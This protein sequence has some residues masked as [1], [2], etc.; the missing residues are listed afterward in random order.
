[1]AA[2][3]T[4]TQRKQHA[5]QQLTDTASTGSVASYKAAAE[6]AEAAAAEPAVLAR[7]AATFTARC[8]QA[9]EAL[10]TAAR[11]G[12]WHEFV[13]ARDQALF[14]DQ[15]VQLAETAMQQRRDVASSAVSTA[16]D[17]CLEAVLQQQA[18]PLAASRARN[19]DQHAPDSSLFMPCLECYGLTGHPAPK[20]QP[21]GGKLQDILVE[22]L[23]QSGNDQTLFDNNQQIIGAIA[24]AIQAVPSAADAS[25]AD[26]THAM[27]DLSKA[28]SSQHPPQNAPAD[29]IP[30]VALTDTLTA[31]RQLGLLQTVTLALHTLQAQA[32][33]QQQS[34]QAVVAQFDLPTEEHPQEL[35][36]AAW[37][38]QQHPTTSHH[39]FA[40]AAPY[41]SPDASG[42]A[43]AVGVESPGF[44]AAQGPVEGPAEGL[45][46]EAE[47]CAQL[48]AGLQA[49]KH[50]QCGLQGFA[51]YTG[52]GLLLGMHSA[53]LFAVLLNAQDVQMSFLMLK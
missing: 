50:G 45:A 2:E 21:A 8:T 13:S 15:Q 43:A 24:Q 18:L 1:M 5:S 23:F 12:S 44:W 31:A 25:T 35:C 28:M 34:H 20:A 14:L 39:I 40:E 47:T 38:Q 3:Q 9:A 19:E 52:L 53:A 30:A 41:T 32:Q 16:V 4:L 7:A 27:A 10:L 11:D 22:S 51:Q 37:Q 46:E 49:G 17:Q 29:A 48:V 36:T 33:L 6:A 42:S 26:W